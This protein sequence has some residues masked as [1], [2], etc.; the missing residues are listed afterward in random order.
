MPTDQSDDR[1]RLGRSAPAMIARGVSRSRRR[2]GETYVAHLVCLDETRERAA[3]PICFGGT[4]GH[5]PRYARVQGGPRLD[6]LRAHS[7]ADQHVGSP[8]GAGH[9][10]DRTGGLR[11]SASRS[12]RVASAPTCDQITGADPAAIGRHRHGR[13]DLGAHKVRRHPGRSPWSRLAGARPAD[14]T[15]TGA[16]PLRG[17]PVVP[18]RSPIPMVVAL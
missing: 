4:A 1:P 14:E 13:W 12:R 17:Q 15:G 7:R 10:A 8:P 5:R 3:P 11:R 2:P 16:G 6:S 18:R 9:G